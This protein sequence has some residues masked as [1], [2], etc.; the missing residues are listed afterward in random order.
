MGRARA[1]CGTATTA[2]PCAFSPAPEHASAPHHRRANR[3]TTAADTLAPQPRPDQGPGQRSPPSRPAR[4]SAPG[5]QSSA[6]AISVQRRHGT[7][8]SLAALIQRPGGSSPKAPACSRTRTT[9]FLKPGVAAAAAIHVPMR[10]TAPSSDSRPLVPP[11]QPS[12]RQPPQ[13]SKTESANLPP[14][15]TSEAAS[16]GDQA[17]QPL[18]NTPGAALLRLEH[19][20]IARH[21]PTS[22]SP[23]ATAITAGGQ[24]GPGQRM[25]RP[26]QQ[27]AM[28][29]LHPKAQRHSDPQRPQPSQRGPLLSAALVPTKKPPSRVASPCVD[30]SGSDPHLYS[31]HEQTTGSTPSIS[32]ITD[33]INS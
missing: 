29:P 15:R 2:S 22:A 24:P 13:S 32:R 18:N 30:H 14:A 9:P 3:H 16:N 5:P 6:A 12:P 11:R 28:A 4:T 20:A 1:G 8:L 10:A 26:H 21:Q 19:A 7:G 33:V 17:A 23:G 25:P 27:T 31:G